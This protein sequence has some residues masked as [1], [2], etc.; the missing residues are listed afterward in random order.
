M[1]RAGGWRV[2]MAGRDREESHRASTPL[3]LFFD[4]VIVI[5]VAA[6]SRSLHHGIAEDHVPESILSYLMVFFAI[7]WAWMSFSWFATAYDTD[8]VPY[9]VGVLVQMSGAIIIAAGVG[10]AFEAGDWTVVTL[11]YVVMRLAT[12][13]LWMRAARG[14]PEHRANSMRWVMGVTIAQVGWILL[15][16]APDGLK[17]PGFLF[18]VVAELFVPIWAARAK[19]MRFHAEHIAER[20]G[21]FTIIVLGESV[22]AGTVAIGTAAEEVAG[23]PDVAILGVALGA[24]LIVFVMWWLYFER[25]S[26]DLLTTIPR[27]FE[28][29]Y[30]HYVIWAAAAAVGAGVA[31][32]VD[33]A[34]HHAEVSTTVAGAA[35]AVPV[36]VYVMGTWLLHDVPR[37]MPAWR[38]ALSPIAA[39]LVLMAPLTATP[40]LAVGVIVVALL[41]AKVATADVQPSPHA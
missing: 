28:W 13:A 10:R 24:L 26:N 35:V 32:A 39:L 14:D 29:G 36:A 4:L 25:S 33:V 18:L 2:P 22:L 23:I 8:D 38:M 40:V 19:R 21:L 15:L 3:E 31:V 17:L 37:P 20:Y 6:A 9:R 16:F 5:A 11:G 34:T 30:G 7:W 12:V 41:V 1:T 27:S